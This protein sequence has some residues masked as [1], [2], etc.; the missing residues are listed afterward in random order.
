MT[1][2]LVAGATLVLPDA[3]EPVLEAI[4]R[5]AV[6]WAFMDLGSA[7][8]MTREAKR[9][10]KSARGV[11][12]GLLLSTSGPFEADQRQRVGRLF[13]CPALTVFGMPETGPIFAS[14]PTWYLDEAIGIPVSNVHVV[15]VDPRSGNPVPTL[16][17]M[18]ESAEVTVWSPLLMA[19]Y[20]GEERPER[21]RDGRFV[22]GVIA[23][24]DANGM[25]YL[26]PD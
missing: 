24:S 23:S 1:G 16:W 4:V 6:G 14:H 2:A 15:P 9:E 20:E 17:E 18:V 13:G 22:T 19:G 26:L 12:G 5:E 21:Y 25:I 10:V 3:D 8:A 7:F 11:L